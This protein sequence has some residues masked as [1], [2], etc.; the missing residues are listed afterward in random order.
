MRTAI[1]TA[2]G[3]DPGAGPEPLGKILYFAY[4]ANMHP[5]QIQARCLGAKLLATAK[6]ADH[7]LAFFGDSFVWDG[8]LE[9]VVPSPGREVWGVI[10][11]LSPLDADS[12]DAWQDARFNGTG[13][14]FHCPVTVR[15]TRGA[16]S[17]VLLYK[18]DLLGA[19]RKPS[20]AYLDHIVQAAVARGLPPAYIEGLRAVAAKKAAY[21]VPVLRRNQAGSLR[22]TTCAECG[23][24]VTG[25]A[26]PVS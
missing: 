15:D 13:A 22:S 26:K 6:L 9:T 23:S 24:L 11:A 10:Y 17:E 8:A 16:W 21:P 2:P 20:Q 18:K 4:G 3:H 12:L 7:Q 5:T 1:T 14:Y 25:E 19:P